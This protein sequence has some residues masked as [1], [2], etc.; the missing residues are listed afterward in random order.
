MLFTIHRTFSETGLPAS[1]SRKNTSADPF[2]V[3]LNILLSNPSLTLRLSPNFHLSTDT[4]P[5]YLY[6]YS[7]PVYVALYDAEAILSFCGSA[8]FSLCPAPQSSSKAQLTFSL[9]QS[10]VPLLSWVS[11]GQP[12]P[13]PKGFAVSACIRLAVCVWCT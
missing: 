10:L 3:T 13:Y 4:I 9:E 5:V 1:V 6:F 2:Y 12:V 8:H 7:E 11:G